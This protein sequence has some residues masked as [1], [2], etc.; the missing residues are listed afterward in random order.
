VRPDR[1]RFRRVLQSALGSAIEMEELAYWIALS[2]VSGIGRARLRR[3][4]D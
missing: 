4:K 1:R 3:L 2:R